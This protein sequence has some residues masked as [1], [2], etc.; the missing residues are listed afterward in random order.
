[1]WSW[2]VV[3]VEA[4]EPVTLAEAKAQCRY[5]STDEDEHFAASITA[6]REHLEDVTGRS[7]VPVTIDLVGP[8]FPARACL[9]FPQPPLRTVTWV[10]YRDTSGTM[11]TMS[12]SDYVVTAPSV[13][14]PPAG[15][16]TLASGA[17]W[18]ATIDEA[19]AVQIRLEVGY[20][21][22]PVALKKAMLIAIAD[23]FA[24]REDRAAFPT[25]ARRLW[26]PYKW[27][28]ETELSR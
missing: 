9:V 4:S 1:M 15:R 18:P 19:D 22:C 6:A 16:I 2:S 24:D 12:A 21:D 13:R 10:K 8:A 17:S 26:L 5:A 14:I 20:T 11:Q 23:W 7:L 27:R 25:R 28:P 3:D